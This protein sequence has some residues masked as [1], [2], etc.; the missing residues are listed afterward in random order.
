MNVGELKIVV[1]QESTAGCP[2]FHADL[3]HFFK[4]KNVPGVGH[5]VL[6]FLFELS[7]LFRTDIVQTVWHEHKSF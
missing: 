7:R 4:S 2:K 1:C 6:N 5:C 3:C